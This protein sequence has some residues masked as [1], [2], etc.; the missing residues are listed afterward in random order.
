MKETKK[1]KIQR[2][3]EAPSNVTFSNEDYYNV[4]RLSKEELDNIIKNWNKPENLNDEDQ[5]SR[6]S[7]NLLLK[8]Y[9]K[10]DVKE[11][12]KAARTITG[13][14][15]AGMI[16]EELFKKAI[17]GK[18]QFEAFMSFFKGSNKK[19]MYT[20][21]DDFATAM[22]ANTITRSNKFITEF[23]NKL[24]YNNNSKMTITNGVTKRF[25]WEVTY[26]YVDGQQVPKNVVVTKDD[27][28]DI[29]NKYANNESG[30]GS[31]VINEYFN[32]D[33]STK[34]QRRA[35]R[36]K[37]VSNNDI[38]NDEFENV[39]KDYNSKTSSR[40]DPKAA[41]NF[42]KYLNNGDAYAISRK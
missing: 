22:G 32:E 15:L 23:I 19:P 41:K 12:A 6:S 38:D 5:R 29:Y 21:L 8:T 34:N 16:I 7:I 3:T 40:I 9:F 30:F 39:I 14:D 26:T 20:V 31:D 27:F 13:K 1:M 11:L 35:N 4:K 18:D 28:E 25:D 24:S 10:N 42:L 37:S 36:N 2:L 33:T 17:A